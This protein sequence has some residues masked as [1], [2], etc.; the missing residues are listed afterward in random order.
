MVWIA[1]NSGLSRTAAAIVAAASIITITLSSPRMASAAPQIV[2]KIEV[3][4]AKRVSA[5]TIVY[6]L[7]IKEGDLLL[8]YLLSF[9]IKKL[10]ALGFFDDI[11]VYTRPVQGGVAL[12]VVVKER[13]IIESIRI[14]GNE[15]I[16][17]DKVRE[18]I[19]ITLHKPLDKAKLARS[20]AA[21]RQLYRLR[22]YNY[23]TVGVEVLKI[24]PGTV[25]V[26]FSVKE[27]AKVKV[28]DILFEG[29]RT[30]SSFKLKG[31]MKTRERF[32]KHPIRACLF[33]FRKLGKF[34][35]DELGRDQ[36]RLER[37]Y[38][39][40][41][42]LQ[43]NVSEPKVEYSE[44]RKGLVIR[45][46]ISE[47]RR[48]TIGKVKIEGN[49]IFSTP[50]LRKLIEHV[51]LPGKI[52]FGL[53]RVNEGSLAPGKP[54][55][56][57]VEEAAI[58]AIRQKYAS[59]GYV[60]ANVESRHKLSPQEGIV[61][62]RL[63]IFEDGQ[64]RLRRLSFKGNTRTRDKVLRREFKLAEGDILDMSKVRE[65][66]ERLGYL[67]FLKPGIKPKLETNRA[68]KTADLEVKV[69]EGRLHELR[70]T[71]T[72]SKYQKFGIG[73][74][75]V[76][77]NFLGYGQTFGLTVHFTSKTRTYDVFFEE[78]YLLDSDYS[79]GAGIYD[80]RTEYDWYTR[81]AAG[82]RLSVGRRLSE[83]LRITNTYRLE[84]VQVSDIGEGGYRPY[85]R[86]I[87][88]DPGIDV[89]ER[90]RPPKDEIGYQEEKSLTSSD[91][92]SLVWDSRDNWIKPTKGLYASANVRVG[93][94]FLGGDTNFYKLGA[95]A[96]WNYPVMKRL[97][98]TAKGKI[99]YADGFSGDALP[100]FERYYLGG[101]MLGGRGFD[102]YELGPK[103]KYGNSVGGNKLLLFTGELFYVVADPL[104]VG[105][106]WDCG[107]VFSEDQKYNLRQLRNSYGLELR[108]YVP[109]FVYPI[110]LIYGVK[111]K[112]YSG[113][114]STNFDFAI[115]MGF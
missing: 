58:E 44:E 85:D 54:Y 100:I 83:H 105:V 107:Q 51:R 69:E 61:D 115:G 64:Y 73:G 12:I 7:K 89:E 41:G 97:I 55:S 103:D 35:A 33:L 49:T 72:Y 86:D 106:F 17:T 45:F 50:T 62:I 36:K 5:E 109:M 110:R 91:A 90:L 47:G 81:E 1:A 82:G 63:L 4:G 53:L 24:S 70:F 79:L 21:I 66:I 77:H 18:K 93:G 39:N 114:E 37:F 112:T 29:N 38:K 34:D 68:A 48:F 42:F 15:K 111:R 8:P 102:T 46:N 25:S 71:A 3:E 65:G 27:R 31:Q 74:S 9:R 10:W 43:V 6:Y 11:K 88:W 92:I 30:F 52:R 78:P 108:I 104:R 67:G 19:E 23:A 32:T 56:L 94:S 22:G 2:K 75:I 60:Y 96:S 16:G 101:A 26:L 76:E 113:E 95:E 98:F 84:R 14:E 80:Y 99:D 59:N 57:R 20:V 40:H 13:P 28:S 87:H